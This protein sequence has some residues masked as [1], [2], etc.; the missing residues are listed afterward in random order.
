[1]LMIKLGMK[2]FELECV[3]VLV[4]EPVDMWAGFV[5]VPMSVSEPLLKNPDNAAAD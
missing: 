1:M 3:A 2:S 4:P 5:P